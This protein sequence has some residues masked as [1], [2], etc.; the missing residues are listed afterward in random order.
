MSKK[1]K[2]HIEEVTE[3]KASEELLRFVTMVP[4]TIINGHVLDVGT[5]VG[6]TQEQC[7]K[8][9]AGGIALDNVHG[10]DDRDVYN[11]QDMYVVPE[12]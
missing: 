8:Y 2:A 7:D 9:R 5:V 4:Q 12:S 3:E 6:L 1:P 10:D 11:V